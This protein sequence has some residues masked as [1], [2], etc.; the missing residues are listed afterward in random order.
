MLSS[1]LQEGTNLSRAIRTEEKE[2]HEYDGGRE[3]GHGFH[4]RELA[5]DGVEVRIVRD[6]QQVPNLVRNDGR[7]GK[8]REGKRSKMGILGF[9][10][11]KR[12]IERGERGFCL[13]KE[14]KGK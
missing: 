12:W 13:V 9:L 11:R 7:E 3:R 5:K 14:V 2:K 8:H 1:D 10:C 6:L 4:L